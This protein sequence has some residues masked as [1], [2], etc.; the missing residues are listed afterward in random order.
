M[1]KSPCETLDFADGYSPEIYANGVKIE[2]RSSEHICSIEN[3]TTGETI[4]ENWDDE[5]DD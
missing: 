4:Y 2:F 1:S 5:E 3:L